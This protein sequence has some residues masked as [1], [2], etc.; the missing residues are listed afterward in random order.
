MDYFEDA[1][2]AD[3]SSGL[4]IC[5]SAPYNLTHTSNDTESSARPWRP[6][7]ITGCELALIPT[8]TAH[9][10]VEDTA[11]GPA[12]THV[13]N[14]G[15]LVG[16]INEPSPS[17]H[18][19]TAGAATRRPIWASDGGRERHLRFNP[20]SLIVNLQVRNSQNGA[21][22]FINTTG[23]FSILLRLRVE[24]N[25]VAYVILDNNAST[26]ANSGFRLNKT[27]G[28][29]INIIVTKGV[30]GQII[31][32]ATYTTA[33]IRVAD[34]YR[35]IR[36]WSTDG[37]TLRMAMDGL[38]TQTFA[39][40]STPGGGNAN[41]DLRIGSNNAGTSNGLD[42]SLQMLAIYSSA[43]S[44]ADYARWRAY[45][46]RASPNSLVERSGPGLFNFCRRLYDF[47]KV[48]GLW[49][50]ANRTVP[51]ASN[52]DVLMTVDNR[53]DAS[54][55]LNRAL[56]ASGAPTA[57]VYRST[58]SGSEWNGLAQPNNSNL[59]HADTSVGTGG[60]WTHLFIVHNTR[61]NPGSHMWGINT[62]NAT[63]MVLTG[64]NYQNNQ[65]PSGG[66]G[67]PFY[68]VHAGGPGLS[69]CLL[70]QPTGFN[71]IELRRDGN[72]WVQRV[73]FANSVSTTQSG[74][75]SPTNIGNS[76]I[77]G[78]E[79]QGFLLANITFTAPLSASQLDTVV[80]NWVSSN[81][82]LVSL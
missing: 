24:A 67:A 53:T 32:N 1:T 22:N 40:T 49:Q 29:Q 16:Q 81:W 20:A 45:V 33:T 23:I 11:T 31:W 36:I 62:L 38:A 79:L 8:H 48:A 54:G 63:Y 15:D 65:V 7:D 77:S 69:A 17:A 56:S 6:W 2:D 14:V 27:S 5:T 4:T 35:N 61:S 13:A 70:T 39:R 3:L 41:S 26:T 78:W 74:S 66:P 42:A 51:V 44:D 25:G 80:R 58:S 64:P 72:Q 50:D 21:F 73:S 52:G 60:M 47:S 76:A 30:S 18:I 82:P 59:A 43:V 75:F 9:M 37:I 19:M 12:A 57:P 71:V 55:H 28:D 10:M 34:G 68:N 46:P